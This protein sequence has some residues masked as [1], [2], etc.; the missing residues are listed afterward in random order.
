LL[1]IRT[2]FYPTFRLKISAEARYRRHGANTSTHNVGGDIEQFWTE[3][4]GYQ[5]RFLEGDRTDRFDFALKAEYEMLP[6][7][8]FKAAVVF[9]QTREEPEQGTEHTFSSTSFWTSL[10]MNF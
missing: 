10:G 2:N 4:A 5:T 7:V 1:W 9:S 3:E 6:G 8:F